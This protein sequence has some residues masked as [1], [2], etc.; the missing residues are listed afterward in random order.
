MKSG[1][2]KVVVN[3]LHVLGRSIKLGL[4]SIKFF[5]RKIINNLFLLFTT[6]S[7][8]E[9]MNSL[10]K[11]TTELVRYMKTDLTDYQI[12]KLVEI[13]KANLEHYQMQANVYGCLKA[14]I[15]KKVLSS[16]IY[17]L[18]DIIAD[19]MI[20]NVNKSVRTTCSQIFVNFLIEYPLEEKRLEQHIHHLI[21]N[22]TYIGKEGRYTVLEVIEKL[23]PQLPTEILDKYSLLLFLS[24]ILRTVNESE[25]DCK[26]K[27]NTT[28]KLLLENV[29]ASKRDDIIKTVLN[30]DYNVKPDVDE[31]MQEDLA[32]V[33]HSS[34]MK[35]VT[36][37]LIGL[38]IS[39]EGEKFA[40]KYFHKTFQICSKEISE[41]AE[42]LK[43]LYT[44]NK[45]EEVRDR[46]EDDQIEKVKREMGDFLTE[47]ALI[48]DKD[49]QG[50]Y[51]RQKV[52]E[53]VSQEECLTL[54]A[55]L[56][57]IEKFV[58]EP[59]CW[60]VFYKDILSQDRGLSF[61]QSVLELCDHY[62]V[63]KQV[64]KLIQTLFDKL[65]E[66]KVDYKTNSN[67]NFMIDDLSLRL[68]R[69]FELIEAGT[70]LGDK[71][72][73]ILVFITLHIIN[74][75]DEKT[76]SQLEKMFDKISFIGRKMMINLTQNQHRLCS[77]LKFF[78]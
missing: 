65:D 73:H 31:S 11:C 70:D 76:Q 56:N 54:S 2:N 67:V 59:A 78:V 25:P 36:L 10:F 15:D 34:M 40:S 6:S 17:D 18:V 52:R 55:A 77:V 21:K 39:I 66:T 30:W 62:F 35:R 41:Q 29:S 60:K 33:S 63:Y 8:S 37:L 50:S 9:F 13:I 23:V 14:L 3:T 42:S 53:E 72:T 51:K 4:P 38:I 44:V 22:L 75:K 28:L 16:H 24:M 61:I 69:M 5:C 43:K 68:A 47:I 7:D 20:T 74:R 48:S 45:E 19:K 57:I 64:C 26:Q 32:Q 1:D 49:M 46:E 58:N 27:A 71:I 12:G